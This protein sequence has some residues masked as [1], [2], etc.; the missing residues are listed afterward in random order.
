MAKDLRRVR[1]WRSCLIIV[2]KESPLSVLYFSWFYWIVGAKIFSGFCRCNWSAFSIASA[3]HLPCS[4]PVFSTTKSGTHLGRHTICLVPPSVEKI[5]LN[6]T[7]PIYNST[8]LLYMTIFIQE[9][10]VLCL[11]RLSLLFCI[12]GLHNKNSLL[13]KGDHTGVPH[14]CFTFLV[15]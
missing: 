5:E 3:A 13:F 11:Q 4:F 15:T 14:A 8:L 12:E 9:N 2:G 1:W 7:F 10:K 6:I